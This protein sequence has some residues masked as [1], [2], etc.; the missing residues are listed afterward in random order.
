MTDKLQD[1]SDGEKPFKG[2]GGQLRQ[3][4]SGNH[5]Q[6]VLSLALPFAGIRDAKQRIR[7]LEERR[8]VLGREAEALRASFRVQFP[9]G[10]VPAYLARDTD[11]TLTPLRWRVSSSY[12]QSHERKRFEFG[13]DLGEEILDSL[14]PMAKAAFLDTELRRLY[15]NQAITTTMYELTRLRSFIIGYT[16]WRRI[17]NALRRD[18]TRC[19]ELGRA[20]ND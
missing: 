3:P 1:R 15:L 5:E 12:G 14:P 19:D 6:W 4:G 8:A 13:S 10:N 17:R 20:N 7:H 11:K 9:R 18:A 16:A 2:K